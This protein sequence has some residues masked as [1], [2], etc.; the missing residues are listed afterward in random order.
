[1]LIGLLRGELQ[2]GRNTLFALVKLLV[3]ALVGLVVAG[4]SGLLIYA[5]WIAGSLVS[6]AFLVALARRR[7]RWRAAVRPEWAL[8]RKL[9]R[10]ALGH[11]ALNLA[12]Q[13]PGLTLPVL[14]TIVLSATANAHFYVAWMVVSLLF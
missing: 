7:P 14:V 3:L 11:H 10:A 2:L 1:A 4:R 13:V 5:T 9:G 8:L 12:L 6:L